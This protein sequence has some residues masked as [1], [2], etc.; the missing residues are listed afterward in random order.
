MALIAAF[1]LDWFL[2][3]PDIPFHPV[4]IAGSA[5]SYCEKSLRRKGTIFEGVLSAV[6][7]LTFTLSTAG[8]S[9]YYAA[10]AGSFWYFVVSTIIIYFSISVRSLAEHAQNV[11]SGLE[12]SEEEGRKELAKIVS[13]DTD[14]MPKEKIVTSAV[15]SVSENYVDAVVSPL[16]FAAVLGPMGAVLFK[17]VSTMDSMIGY[18][19]EKFLYYGRF[20]AR[21]DDVLNFI[22]ARLSIIPIFIASILLRLNTKN[23][24]RCFMR[25]RLSHASPN[26]AHPMSAFAGALNIRLGGAVS[27]FGQLTDKPYIG[28][29]ERTPETAD[30]AKS[31]NLMETSSLIWA[32]ICCLITLWKVI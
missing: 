21:F 5:V 7:T 18:K 27:Y 16:L 25:Y 13:R 24:I 11:Q 8:V 22:P 26:S 15:E 32:I 14:N 12:I 28:D 6:I 9:L 31:I 2:G 20:A 19:N 17:T 10:K 30:I 23:A 1:W 29:S 3:E 4:R